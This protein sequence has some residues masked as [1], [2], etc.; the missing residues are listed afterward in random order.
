MEDGRHKWFDVII[1]GGGPS[2][3]QTASLLADSG[4]NV[5]LFD[6]HSEIGEGVVCSGVVSQEAFSRYD[7]S[8]ESIVGKLKEAELFSPGGIQVPYSHPET[9]A[10]VVDRHIFDSKLGETATKRGAE[11]YLNTKVSA[12][13]VNDKFVEGHLKTQEGEKRVHANIAVIATGVS[14]VLQSALGLGRPKRIVKGIQIEV[15]TNHNDRLRVYFGSRFS[16]GFFG[17]AIPLM[18][19]KTRIG[20]MT[21]G[22][23]L[24]GLKN[25][26]SEVGPY[27]DSCT[28]IGTVKRR[29]IAF[30]NI[31]RSYADRIIAVGEAAGHIKTTTGGGIYYGLISAEIASQVIKKAFKKGNFERKTLSEYEKMWRKSLGKEIKF[32]EYFHKFYSRLDDSLVDKLFHAANQ[33][34]LLSF[35]ADKGKF[36]WHREAVIK[37]LRSPNLRRVLWNGLI[38]NLSHIGNS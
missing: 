20:V 2:G 9:A 7:L 8:T 29:G 4:L 18:N 37:I 36:D 21:N 3:L 6:E 17:W 15:N 33:D 19:G 22:N 24:E 5:A 13:F 26:L 16:N 23:A 38:S 28:D 11:V 27:S 30:G 34:S 14:F 25:V 1:V 31:G 35:I 12:L 10:V 32:G